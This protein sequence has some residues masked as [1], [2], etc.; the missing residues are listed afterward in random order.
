MSAT[1]RLPSACRTMARAAAWAV[2][3][4]PVRLVRITRSKA[5]RDISSAG[6]AVGDAGIAD[7]QAQRPEAGLHLR[8]RG[9]GLVFLCHVEREGDGA[10]PGGRDLGG[11]ALCTVGQQVGDQYGRAVVRQAMR[12]GLADAGAPLSHQGYVT[13]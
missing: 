4:Q 3:K 12:D 13:G 9:G 10:Q 7:R 8:H 5:A 2:T 1:T 11:H 6:H